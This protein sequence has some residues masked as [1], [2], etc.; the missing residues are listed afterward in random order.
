MLSQARRVG[1]RYLPRLAKYVTRAVA[2]GFSLYGAFTYFVFYGY[3]HFAE[4]IRLPA[5]PDPG[6]VW[7]ALMAVTRLWM[8]HSGAPEPEMVEPVRPQ[9]VSWHVEPAGDRVPPGSLARRSVGERSAA[10]G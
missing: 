5:D 6:P 7:R 4:A 2:A 10:V 9:P 8:R 3:D 1:W